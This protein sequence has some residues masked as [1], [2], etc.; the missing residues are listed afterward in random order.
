[1]PTN[2]TAWAARPLVKLA[3]ETSKVAIDFSEI[4]ATGET[5]TGSPTV[6]V[7]PN[8]PTITGV[9]V[10]TDVWTAIGGGSNI[11]IGKGVK[12]TVA[13]GAAGQRYELTVLCATSDTGRTAGGR[14]KLLVE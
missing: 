13:G 11:G 1:M 3:G 10:L 12:M 6:T 8:G 5:L 14:V 4:L 7:A 2:D 9:A